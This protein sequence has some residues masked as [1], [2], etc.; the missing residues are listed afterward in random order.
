MDWIKA[1][2]YAGA[3]TW[4]IDMD[5]F[6]GLCGDKKNPLIH[7]LY[8]NMKDYKVPMPS[9]S[10]TPRVIITAVNIFRLNVF[11]KICFY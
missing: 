8:E 6:H 10:T 9:Y 11:K 5:D 3:M 1:K 2:G 7:I 4:A